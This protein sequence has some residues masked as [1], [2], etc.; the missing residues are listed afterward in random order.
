MVVGRI[1]SRVTVSTGTL[2]RLGAHDNTSICRRSRRAFSPSPPDGAEANGLSGHHVGS[3]GFGVERG[4]ARLQGGL[5][6]PSRDR[7][8]R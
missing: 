7:R 3:A 2:R 4:G 5:S 6:Q 1:I 8:G